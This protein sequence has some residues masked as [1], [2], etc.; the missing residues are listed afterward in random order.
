MTGLLTGR[1]SAISEK[2]REKQR[3]AESAAAFRLAVLEDQIKAIQQEVFKPEEIPNLKVHICS[4]VAPDSPPGNWM[5]VYIHSKLM[6]VDDVFTT[7]GSA[8][9]NTRSMQVDSELN[10]AHEWASTT[11]DLRRRLWDL[12]TAGKGAQ[13][14]PKEAFDAWQNIIKE[15]KKRKGGGDKPY[16][17]LVEFHYAPAALTNLD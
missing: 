5:P 9:I 7:H 4:L 17:P 3:D 10:I 1:D 6:I 16:A 8:N 13:D 11:K 15:N 12:H 14:E 2:A